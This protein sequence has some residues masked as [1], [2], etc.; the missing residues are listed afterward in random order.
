MGVGVSGAN[1]NYGLYNA[2]RGCHLLRLIRFKEGDILLGQSF[3]LLKKEKEKAKNK[4]ITPR[5]GLAYT[6]HTDVIVR[7]RFCIH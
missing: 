5:A 1:S 6:T 4:K 3:R 2:R 7:Q